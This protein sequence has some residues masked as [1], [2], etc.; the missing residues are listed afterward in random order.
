MDGF[1]SDPLQWITEQYTWWFTAPHL[2]VLAN[3]AFWPVVFGIA[4]ARAWYL[5]RRTRNE[6]RRMVAEAG[7]Y[8]ELWRKKQLERG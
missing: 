4:M 8:S 5:D 7:G 2:V 6:G 3:L 1:Y